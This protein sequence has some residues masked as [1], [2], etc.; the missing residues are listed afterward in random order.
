MPL[1]TLSTDVNNQFGFGFTAGIRG[2][3]SN[4]LELRGGISWTGYRVDERS[5]WLRAFASMLNASIDEDRLVLRS[6]VL[7]GELL[8]F[9]DDAG[10]GAYVLAGAGIQRAQLYAEHRS[11]DGEGNEHVSNLATWPAADT[12]YFCV[13]AGYQGASQAF[14]ETKFQ[15][16]RYQG[17]TGYRLTDSP[18]QGRPSPR[19]AVSLTLS[20]GVRF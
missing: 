7:S 3:I 9:F 2:R 5:L 10:D 1:A 12:P 15:Y 17:V 6:Y 14:I 11:T 13:G 19:D 20:V 4:R 8:G 18:L 16:W